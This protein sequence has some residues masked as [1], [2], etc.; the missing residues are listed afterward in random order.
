MSYPKRKPKRTRMRK[1]SPGDD[2]QYGLDQ[3]MARQEL[4]E[5]NK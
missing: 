3:E 4:E 1:R 2:L 5:L